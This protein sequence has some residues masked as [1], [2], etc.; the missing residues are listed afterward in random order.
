M[1]DRVHWLCLSVATAGNASHF[2]LYYLFFVPICKLRRLVD[3][4]FGKD[5]QGKVPIEKVMMLIW[6]F[7]DDPS[8]VQFMAQFVA[9]YAGSRDVFDGVEFYLPQLAHMIIHLEASWDDAILERFALII[10]QQSA[11]A[12]VRDLIFGALP[13]RDLS[14]LLQPASA[15]ARSARH[16]AEPA[17]TSLPPIFIVISSVA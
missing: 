3:D 10:A 4:V 2:T 16:H 15:T 13:S 11:A 6:Q 7:R 17:A 12:M 5:N 14:T 1:Y 9:K 8:V